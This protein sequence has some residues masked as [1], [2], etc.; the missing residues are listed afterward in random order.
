MFDRDDDDDDDGVVVDLSLLLLL[1]LRRDEE[2]SLERV[3]VPPVELR[4]VNN[5]R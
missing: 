5:F 3:D 2:P 1:L 4:R